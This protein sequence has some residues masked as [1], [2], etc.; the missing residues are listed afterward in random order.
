VKIDARLEKSA[1]GFY[2]IVFFL[3]DVLQDKTIQAY[4]PTDGHITASRAYMRQCKKPESR[5]EYREV[6]DCLAQYFAHAAYTAKKA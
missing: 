5:E 4:T 2:P 6:F 1:G 3:D